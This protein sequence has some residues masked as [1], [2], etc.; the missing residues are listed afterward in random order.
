MTSREPLEIPMTDRA[1]PE[2]QRASGKIRAATW[3]DKTDA[4][5]I[6]QAGCNGTHQ[7]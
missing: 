7:P 1:N 6:D 2:V 3:I 4:P 5:T